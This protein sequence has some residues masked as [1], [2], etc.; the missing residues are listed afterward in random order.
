[1][2]LGTLQHAEL[3]QRKAEVFH[4]ITQSGWPHFAIVGRAKHPS[5]QS[6]TKGFLSS[7]QR[8]ETYRIIS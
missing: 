6:E 2:N 1:M 3:Y 7:P 4:T 5:S 8:D